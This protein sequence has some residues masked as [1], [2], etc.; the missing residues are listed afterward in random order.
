MKSKEPFKTFPQVLWKNVVQIELSLV[1]R[2]F[3][4]KTYSTLHTRAACRKCFALKNILL[5]VTHQIIVRKM[6]S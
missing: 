2:L 3:Q 5:P 6:Y 1:A 4:V